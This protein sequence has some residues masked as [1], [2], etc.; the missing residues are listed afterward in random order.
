MTRMP[1]IA[2]AHQAR[3]CLANLNLLP[4]LGSVSQQRD[5]Q[6]EN[7][8]ISEQQYLASGCQA[9]NRNT[10]VDIQIRFKSWLVSEEDEY[11]HHNSI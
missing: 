11:F 10:T 7:R 3:Q 4:A 9:V 1:V 5:L 6:L 2:G 8:V